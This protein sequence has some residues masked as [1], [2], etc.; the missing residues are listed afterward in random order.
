MQA[1]KQLAELSAP[2]LLEDSS[3]PITPPLDP[4][5]APED[6]SAS[7]LSED[8]VDLSEPEP[9]TGAAGESVSG[10]DGTGKKL[11]EEEE[12][13]LV[14]TCAAFL[15]K[16]CLGDTTSTSRSTKVSTRNDEAHEWLI[17]DTD[18]TKAE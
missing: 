1:V 17:V 4:T 18:D 6:P 12:W 8:L 14:A 5:K 7:S 16:T 10:S 2:K 9:E 3:T 13:V 11:T 15:S